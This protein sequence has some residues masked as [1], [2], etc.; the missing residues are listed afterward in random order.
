MESLARCAHADDIS[1]YQHIEAWQEA[2]LYPYE[3]VYNV[4]PRFD[5]RDIGC[6]RIFRV[7]GPDPRYV[8][9]PY[10]VPAMLKCG[11]VLS[12]APYTNGA[13]PYDFSGEGLGVVGL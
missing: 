1:Y 11:D 10:S 12:L 4:V 9:Y 7:N 5:G 3:R 8:L 6:D 2:S 13:V